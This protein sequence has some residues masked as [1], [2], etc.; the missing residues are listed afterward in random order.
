MS[1]P[2]P[3][4]FLCRLGDLADPGARGFAY[5]AGRDYFSLFLVRRAQ[6]VY[7][8][9][10]QCPHA[11]TTLDYPEDRFLTQEGSEIL[12]GTHGARFTIDTGR[13]TLGP[14]LGRALTRFPIRI[15]GDQ[16]FVAA[17]GD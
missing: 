7:G 16:I 14:C 9:V 12:C 3:G 10:N 6:K 13:C 2:E 1:R 8:Y 15:E 11:Y 5:G 17:T 4:S